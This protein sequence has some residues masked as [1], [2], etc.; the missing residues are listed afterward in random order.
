MRKKQIFVLTMMPT[1]GYLS[2]LHV[3]E[4]NAA[5]SSTGKI[6]ASATEIIDTIAPVTS[7]R[8]PN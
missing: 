4:M 5:T 3:M 6:A 7:R 1:L 2:T 8:G